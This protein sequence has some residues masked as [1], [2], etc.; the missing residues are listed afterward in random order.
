MT[1]ISRLSV[2][3]PGD[4]FAPF[5]DSLLTNNSD[6][7]AF[8][9]PDFKVK[10]ANEQMVRMVGVSRMTKDSRIERVLPGL[11]REIEKILKEIQSTGERYLAGLNSNNANNNGLGQLS[12]NLSV[13]PVKD[14]EGKFLGWILTLREAIESQSKEIENTGIIN[15][16]AQIQSL[17]TI[18]ENSTVGIVLLDGASFR[19]KWANKAHLEFLDESCRL[20][21]LIGYFYL[22]YL[23]EGVKTDLAQILSKAAAT[24]EPIL[25]EMIQQ[26]DKYWNCHVVPVS[27]GTEVPDLVFVTHNITEQVSTWK[28]ANEFASQA[29]NY[30]YQLEA[31]IENMEDGVILFDLDGRI[32]KLN[33]A[34][35]QILGY[36]NFEAC[37]DNLFEI[38][39]DFELYDLDG[40]SIMLEEWPQFRIVRGEVVRNFEAAAWRANVGQIRYL[41]YNGTLIKD[42]AQTS[43]LAIMTIRDI[44]ER[45]SLL[46]E[47]EE[48]HSR[49]Q[50]VLEQMPCGVIMFDACSLKQILVNKKYN[51]IWQI[52][53]A[54]SELTE[55]Y[56]PGKMFH[57]DGRPYQKEELPIFRSLN[58]G[59]IVSNEEMICQRKNGPIMN[60]ICNSTPILD[61]EGNIVAG[62]IVFSDITEL[63]EATTKAALANQLQQI[64]EFLPDGIF[65]TDHERNVIAW[66]RALE[67]L[68]GVPEQDVIGAK[69]KADLFEGLDRLM[70]IDDI[71]NGSSGENESMIHKSGDVISKQVLFPSLNH[72]D[73][74][75]LDI[76]ATPIRNEHG[77]ILGVIEII[78]DITNQREMEVE[79]IRM[80]K[81]ESL[82][83]L[84]GGIAH[85]FNNILA[86]II[87][88]LQLATIKLKKRQDISKYLEN[89]IETTYKASSLTKQLL[90]FAKGGGPVKK[91][92]SLSKLVRETVNFA[93]CGSKIK[94]VFRLPENLWPVDADEGQITQVINNLIINAEQAMPDG[95]IININGENVTYDANSKYEPGRYVKLTVTDHGEG[96]PQEIVDKIF[97]PFFTTKKLG[98]GLGLSTSYSIIKKHNGYLELES[99][100]ETGATFS[101][102]LPAAKEELVAKEQ[103]KEINAVVKAKVLLLDDEDVIRNVSG[104]LLSLFGYRVVLAKDGKEAIELYQQAKETGDPFVAVVMDLTIPGG[105]GG[106]ETMNN[107]R[108]IDP[109]IKAIVSSGYANDP[110]ISDYEKYGF[111]GVVIKPYKFDDLLLELEKIIEKSQLPLDLTY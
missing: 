81:L 100:S 19:V 92:V 8:I 40:N 78:R 98:S 57:S 22:D 80:Q 59:E 20:D 76:K 3:F 63:K 106:L 42:S 30:L 68:T 65:V 96:V 60:V 47:L 70:L 110:V 28:K 94:A 32:L 49:L 109:N 64:I 13:S 6:G 79:A 61:R 87:A 85:D 82:G 56:Q 9:A 10:Y 5:V 46:R 72:R 35:I 21:A 14:K 53:K 43:T 34:A 101:I 62:V 83:I 71:L 33:T 51:E 58:N 95:G 90:T 2:N 36:D 54:G 73:N 108:R 69:V 107:L 74:V 41:S 84:A 27:I 105:M 38:R 91:M 16:T 11:P 44:S 52:P 55:D 50:A 39:N 77:S 93:L 102:L 4:D 67:T 26:G 24:R 48:E 25:M 88:N 75:L 103:P 45:E 99:S 111:C 23:P 86:A 1:I 12:L 31:V 18:Y 15:E 89:T 37:P 17:K 104:E 7:I 29:E 97:D 66:N